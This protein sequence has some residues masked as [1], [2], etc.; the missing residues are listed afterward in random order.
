MK[1]EHL[2]MI[3][4]VPLWAVWAHLAALSAAAGGGAIP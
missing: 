4:M 3:G 1:R 2:F